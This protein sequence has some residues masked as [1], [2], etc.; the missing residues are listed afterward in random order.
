MSKGGGLGNSQKTF[1]PRSGTLIKPIEHS[2]L[3][4]TQ[5][6]LDSYFDPVADKVKVLNQSN[7]KTIES[8]VLKKS[9]PE[10]SN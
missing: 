1:N 6:E 10:T 2:Y 7:A 8:K 4:F 9:D 5:K 3:S